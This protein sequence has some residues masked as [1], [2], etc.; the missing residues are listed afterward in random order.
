LANWCLWVKWWFEY[1][2]VIVS[3]L[4]P[5][6][7]GPHA[8]KFTNYLLFPC[9][10]QEKDPFTW[11]IRNKNIINWCLWA[12]DWFSSSGVVS[13]G[14]SCDNLANW[15]L[16]V[17]WWFEYSGVV[18]SCILPVKIGP[19]ASK[20]YKLPIVP[21]FSWGKRPFHM[22]NQKQRYYQLMPVSQG[23]IFI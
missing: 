13:L 22:V 9:F 5:V 21:M 19:H 3:C 16:S 17:K 2:G 6:E 20:F 1:S 11:W 12:K 14:L 18:V 15:F 8:P 23:L 4:L 7:M 10:P